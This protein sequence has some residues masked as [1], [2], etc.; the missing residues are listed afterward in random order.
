[1]ADLE[2]VEWFGVF[3]VVRGRCNS[4]HLVPAK[5]SKELERPQVCLRYEKVII[6]LLACHGLVCF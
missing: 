5:P 6:R 3:C 2:E 4:V 1:M